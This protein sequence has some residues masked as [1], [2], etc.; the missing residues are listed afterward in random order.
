MTDHMAL[1]NIRTEIDRIDDAILAL[2][3]E[4]GAVVERLVAAKGQDALTALRPA[5]EAAVL[6]RLCMGHRGILPTPFVEGF[7]RALMGAFTNL[8]KPFGIHTLRDCGLDDTL[9]RDFLRFHYG[10]LIPVQLHE[11]AETLWPTLAANTADVAVLPLSL[12]SACVASGAFGATHKILAKLPMFAHTR[13]MFPTPAY[14]IGHRDTPNPAE[15]VFVYALSFAQGVDT[16]VILANFG[17]THEAVVAQCASTALIE[18]TEAARDMFLRNL[19]AA[20]GISSG[21]SWRS[22][23][24]FGVEDGQNPSCQGA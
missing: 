10:C 1:T 18:I 13:Q 20:N 4:R 7:W 23:G 15:D 9:W 19:A 22:L 21:I 17:L 16:A 3:Q 14:T 8:Q 5:R 12:V 6:K 24:S 11:R 2:L